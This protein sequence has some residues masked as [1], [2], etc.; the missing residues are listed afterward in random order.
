MVTSIRLIGMLGVRNLDSW[1]GIELIV[2]QIAS[3]TAGNQ[4]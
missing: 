2:V 3:Y 1:I 4:R